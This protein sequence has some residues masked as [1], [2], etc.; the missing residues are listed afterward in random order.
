[1]DRRNGGHVLTAAGWLVLFIAGLLPAAVSA[2]AIPRPDSP[3]LSL[4]QVFEA[5]WLRQPEAAALEARREAAQAER[6]AAQAWTPEPPALEVLAR[7]DQVTRDRGLREQEVGISL[8]LW[9]PGER[10]RSSA[11]AEAESRVVETSL[12]AARLRLA[13]AV[14]EAYWDWAR[15]RVE[16]ERATDQV[17]NAR[18]LAADVAARFKAGDL[19][20]SDQHLAEGAVAAA[21]AA[22]AQAM[23][24]EVR[25]EQEVRAL[26]GGQTLS[27]RVEARPIP[28]SVPVPEPEPRIDATDDQALRGHPAVDDLLTRA[29]AADRAAA[30]ALVRSR[31]NPDL[32]LIGGRARDAFGESFGQSVTVAVRIPFG[33]GERYR[34][35]IA[36][37]R[38][39]ATELQVIAVLQTERV[40]A[41]QSA[42]RLRIESARLQV[43]AAERRALLAAE[44][45]TFF[46]RSFRLGETDLPARLRVEAEAV[47][48]QRQAVLS[49]LELFTI[50][51][52]WRQALGLLPE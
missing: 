30:L 40:A 23:A 51:S 33:A 21:E 43:V 18:R 12:L 41:A 32:T 45:R 14:R 38:A 4:R 2:Q 22:R 27:P 29:A 49:R 15:A 11:L 7:T 10:A 34:A 16:V 17:A 48:A 25:A 1:M 20:R 36:R 52:E 5:A 42:G 13:G 19:A 8:P 50:I 47:E 28:L 26:I 37:A 9:L 44:S 3:G 35:R 24:A 46:E 39:D 31:A 6:R